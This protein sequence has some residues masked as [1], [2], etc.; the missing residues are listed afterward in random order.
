MI[1]VKTTPSKMTPSKETPQK[2]D[3][4]TIYIFEGSIFSHTFLKNLRDTFIIVA[5]RHEKS[6]K[7]TT[8]IELT[9][10]MINAI[11]ALISNE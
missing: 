3:F 5:N 1:H 4:Q 9:R 10:F 11:S 7:A 6:H 2:L 8:T